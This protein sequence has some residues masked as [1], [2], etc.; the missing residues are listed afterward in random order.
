[1]ADDRVEIVFGA[2]FG[3]LVAAVE[4][5]RGLLAGLATQAAG[6]GADFAASGGLMGK[7]AKDGTEAWSEAARFIGTNLDTVLK[8][9]LLG[10]QTWQQAM[11]RIFAD[12]AVSFAETV[13]NMIV[14]WSMFEVLGGGSAI[15]GLVGGLFS[16]GD[17]A[18]AIGIGALAMFQ[19]GAWSIPRDMVAMVHAGEMILPA[20]VAA[21]ARAGGAVPSFPAG[22]G[23]AAPAAG[24]AGVTLNV[25][26]Q[27]M[28]A[29]GVAQ[30]ANANA[31]TLAATVARYMANNP[32]AHG[33]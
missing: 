14:N 21:A 29:A 23:A 19:E 27:A 31:R 18:G 33:D 32:S 16:G 17:A 28:D 4:Q 11:A 20:D 26:V 15:G 30:W 8:G 10:T 2:E 12:L 25:S 5:I 1:M 24:A 9:V 13:A 7:G 6:V 22:S 3:E